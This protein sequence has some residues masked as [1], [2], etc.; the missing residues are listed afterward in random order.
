MKNTCKG[1]ALQQTDPESILGFVCWTSFFARP[2]LKKQLSK[3]TKMFLQTALGPMFFG[4][5]K[6]VGFHFVLN[7]VFGSCRNGGVEQGY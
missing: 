7:F 6:A 4:L 3:S 1:G 5:F 2:R